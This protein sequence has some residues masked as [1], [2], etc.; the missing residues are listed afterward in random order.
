LLLIVLQKFYFFAKVL[1][2]EAEA[3]AADVI[4]LA[5]AETFSL[6][7]SAPALPILL[8]PIS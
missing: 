6:F 5:F 2:G 4:A 8:L 7:A 1:G 3:A